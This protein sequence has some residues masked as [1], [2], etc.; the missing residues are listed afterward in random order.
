[1]IP[2]WLIKKKRDGEKLSK[3]EIQF[4]INSYTSGDIP[5]YQMSAFTMAIYFQGMDAVETAH[6]TEAM[7]HSGDVIDTSSIPVATVDK[8]ST[9]GIGDKVSLILAPLVACCDL[10]VPMVSGRGL[11]LTGGTLD[12]LE[13]IP[14]YRTDLSEQEFINTVNEV[15]VSITGQTSSLAPADKAIYALRDVTATVESIPLITASIMSKKLAAGVDSLV[16]DVKYGHGAFMTELADARELAQSMVAVGQAMNKN[17]AAI[18]TC[19]NSPLGHAV[20]NTLE[21]IEVIEALKGN[22]PKDLM[23]VTMALAAE[24]LIF[25]KIAK[26]KQSAI[27]ILQQHIDSGAALAKFKAM[28]I[29]HG[30]DGSFIDDPSKFN[31]ATLQQA[32]TA[33]QSGY[34]A[35][36]NAELVGKASLLLGAGR[37]TTDDNVDH[38]VG[39]SDLCKI[40][41][42]IEHGEILAVLHG[43]Q[44]ADLDKAK[45]LLAE[46]FVVSE[47]LVAVS[48]RIVEYV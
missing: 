33:K 24:M 17:V 30:G 22:G 12:K 16:L 21:I 25:G 19:M 6:M 44:Q 31:A 18:I 32:F 2:Q 10:A 8:H 15:G 1:M 28:V 41:D 48:S 46:A 7:M 37:V 45:A 35:A 9:G 27:D 11:G 4:M 3:E 38:A 43:Q 13:A 40:G 5:D 26:D 14:G 36:V 42:R 34:I 39:I 23:E 20:G 47:Q 29:E